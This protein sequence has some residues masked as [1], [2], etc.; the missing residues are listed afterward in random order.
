[1]RS[2]ALFTESKYHL[3]VGDAARY[4]RLT[5]GLSLSQVSI[6]SKAISPGGLSLVESG[7]R[8]PSLE[9]LMALGR[10]YRAPLIWGDF[11]IELPIELPE[12]PKNS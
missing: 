12:A 9:T 5:A 6:Y 7:K 3:S 1:M 11:V 10:L 4:F 2:F 8:S